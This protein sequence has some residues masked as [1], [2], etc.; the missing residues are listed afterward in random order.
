MK[1]ITLKQKI[2][3]WIQ[4]FI[5]EWFMLKLLVYLA[6]LVDYFVDYDIEA[7]W[8]IVICFF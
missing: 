3:W 2:L 5:N 4:F 1:G 8:D 6:G 7:G